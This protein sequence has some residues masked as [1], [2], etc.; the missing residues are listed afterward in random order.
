MKLISARF[1]NLIGLYR[2]SGKEEIYINFTKCRHK[3]ILIMGP[4]GHGKSTLINALSPLPESASCYVEG[5]EGFKE[6]EYIDSGNIY[7]LTIIYP[8]TN[9]GKRG[10]TKAFFKEIRPSGEEIEYNAT[11]NITSYKSVLYDKFNLDPNFI[12]LSQLSMEDKGIV[13]KTPT[14]RKKFVSNILNTVE[15]YNNIL[16][17]LTKR[18]SIFRSMINSITSKIDTIGDEEILKGRL[19]SIE[20]RLGFLMSEK[21]KIQKSISENEA[22]INLIDPDGSMQ[23]LYERLSLDLNKINNDMDAIVLSVKRYKYKDEEQCA[24]LYKEVSES[25]SKIDMDIKY[26][27]SYISD[28]LV[29]REEESKSIEQKRQR[30]M[31]LTSD[32]LYDDL[33]NNISS[34]KNNIKEYTNIFNTIGIENFS[35]TKEEYITGLNTL[36]ELKDMVDSIRSYSSMDF[37]KKAVDNVLREIDLN[38]DLLEYNDYKNSL[39]MQ[40]NEARNKISYYNGLLKKLDVL[41][42]R[43]SKCNINNCSFI[44]DALEAEANKPQQMID[45]YNEKIDKLLSDLDSVIE[46][47]DN[48]NELLRLSV[49]INNIIRSINNNSSILKKLPN[50]YIFSDT[51]L[52]LQKLCGGDT[53]NE[54]NELYKYINYANIFEKYK[55]DKEALTKLESEFKIYESKNQIIE[56]INKDIED[57]TI[58]LNG[59]ISDI[60]DKN[61]KIKQNTLLLENRY[62]ELNNINEALTLFNSYNVLNT[63]KKDILSKI[64]T[65]SNNISN[66]EKCISNLNNLNGT[67]ININNEIK[68]ISKESDEIKYSLTKLHEYKEELSEYN[69]KYELTET[70]KDYSNPTKKGIQNVFIKMYMGKT[71][72]MSNKLLSLLFNGTLSLGKY[73]IDENEFRIPCISSTSNIPNDDIKS[74]SSG[75]KSMISMVI[76][77]ALL[78]QSSTKYNILKLDELDGPLDQNNRS[79]FLVVL[80]MI[81]EM[82]DVENCLMI[83]HS[84]EA[85]LSNVDI[86]WL[87]NENMQPPS[88]NI[89]YSYQDTV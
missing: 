66:I 28:L 25:I 16:K 47:I 4:N 32:F 39:E 12:A 22:A 35:I 81:M 89:I 2:P 82:L 41:E 9:V 64:N 73:V 65:V 11:G 50:G 60:E 5:K 6:I 27:K 55:Y 48:N 83:S 86:I 7:K 80:D 61:N 20:T 63:K 24:K 26:D 76:S 77:F 44:K 1:R 15:A 85:E 49:T 71:I 67:L 21:E 69:E 13:D 43:P 17:A 56:E 40:L 51:N 87:A 62:K 30:V 75:E 70:I 45:L 58:K 54:I 46:I 29:S 18:S 42:K 79:Q 10:Q 52:F 37:I 68:P 72:S 34:L 36:K 53:F 31:S 88:G 38:K 8:I 57:L 59:I 19:Q 84:S 23:S 3:I 14:E 78:K 74:C 33:V